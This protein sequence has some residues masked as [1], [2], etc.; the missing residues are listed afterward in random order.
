MTV[1]MCYKDYM[2]GVVDLVLV[3][4]CRINT[5]PYLVDVILLRES[6]LGKPFLSKYYNLTY[7]TIVIM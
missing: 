2:A 3:V 5:T 7:N 1:E 6:I 4:V